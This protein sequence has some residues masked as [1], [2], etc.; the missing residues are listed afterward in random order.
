MKIDWEWA[1]FLAV[2]GGLAVLL[3]MV[4]GIPLMRP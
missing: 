4:L 1:G 2:M 3:L